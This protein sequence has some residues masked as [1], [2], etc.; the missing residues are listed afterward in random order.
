MDVYGTRARR[1]VGQ[2]DVCSER[3]REI[4]REKQRVRERERERERVTGGFTSR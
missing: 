4:A 3:E 1:P 2:R